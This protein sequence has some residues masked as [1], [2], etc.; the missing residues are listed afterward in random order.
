MILRYLWLND[1]IYIVHKNCNKTIIISLS[2]FTIFISNKYIIQN[3]YFNKQQL[4]S[5]VHKSIAGTNK[6]YRPIIIKENT[7]V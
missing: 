6:L 5:Y 2:H 7:L 1:I 4:A 3:T